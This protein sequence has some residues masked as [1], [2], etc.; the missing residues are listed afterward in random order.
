[1]KSR[2]IADL[3]DLW[4][5]FNSKY[6]GGKLTPPTAIRITKSASVWGKMVYP[7]NWQSHAVPP[8]KIY[9]A[10]DCPLRDR[11][12]TLLHEMVHQYQLQVQR[13]SKECEEHTGVFRTYCKWIERETGF[14]V[15]V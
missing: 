11:V 6:F 3:W 13:N 10:Y 5:Y 15:R 9:I 4:H 7:D 1:M 8:V 2:K 14:S 12:G